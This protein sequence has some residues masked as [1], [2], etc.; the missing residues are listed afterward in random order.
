MTR[1]VR[2]IDMERCIGCRS[3][4]AACHV[5]NH[6]SPDAPWN[7]MIEREVGTYPHMR[8][9]FAT[10]GCMHCEE[11]ACMKA[12]TITGANAIS[13]NELGVVIIDYEKCINCG[14]CAAVC[15]YGVP[16]PTDTVDDLYPGQKKTPYAFA[17]GR[18]AFVASRC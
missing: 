12:C 8:T 4:V 9:V 5:E 3:C 13:K 6:Y 15:P 14:Y 16:Q 11:P 7:I 18:I 1:L 10:M 17:G 2:V